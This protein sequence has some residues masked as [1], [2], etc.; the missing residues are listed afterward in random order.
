MTAP[1]ISLGPT[2][3]PLVRATV[4]GVRTRVVRSTVPVGGCGSAWIRWLRHRASCHE[5]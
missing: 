4:A 2:A 3:A 1:P 5:F